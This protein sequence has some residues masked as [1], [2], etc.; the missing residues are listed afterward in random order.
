MRFIERFFG[1]IEWLLVSLFLL[2]LPFIYTTQLLDPVLYSRFLALTVFILL[3]TLAFSIRLFSNKVT[4]YFTKVDKI[5]FGSALAYLFINVISSFGVI[6]Y[7]EALFHLTKETSYILL[8]FYLYQLLRNNSKGKDVLIKSVLIMAAFYLAIGFVQLWR[9]DFTQFNAATDNYGYYFR[10]AI[11]H[12]LST[13][14][15]V[16]LFASFLFISLPFSIYGVI[17]YRKFWRIFSA[18]VLVSALFFI[19]ILA[20]K[21]IWGATALA[22]FIGA[23]LLYFYLFVLMPKQ[24]GV[25]LSKSMKMILLLVPITI[26]VSGYFIV[27]KS[28]IKLV[29][30]VSDKISQV[31]D[32]ETTLQQDYGAPMPTS[33]QTRVYVWENTIKLVKEHPVFGIGGGQW[34]IEY[35]K[36]GL[37]RFEHDIRNGTMLFQRPH[38]DFLWILSENGIM[39]FF[40]YMIIY[41]G[42]LVVA[43]YNFLKQNEW[44]VRIFSALAFAFLIGFMVDMFVSFPR[45]RV[46]HNSMLAILFALVLLLVPSD[47]KSQ[48]RIPSK[49]YKIA[50]IFFMLILTSLNVWAAKQYF[51]GE[52]AARAIKYGIKTKNFNL[53]YRAAR[54]VQNTLY[55]LDNFT[56]PMK[57]YEGVA[58]TSLKNLE[59]AKQTFLEAYKINPYHLQVINNLAT[60]YDLTGDKQTALKYYQLALDISPR[61]K[62]AL[63]NKSIV[64]YNLNEFDKAMEY[65]L[66]IPANEKN[67]DKF[68]ATMLTICKRKAI[69]LVEKCDEQKFK[70]WI[71]DPNKVK[72]TFVKVQKEKANFDVILL[73]ELAK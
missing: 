40:F 54:S 69:T 9:S 7:K 44:P 3:L 14:A 53:T 35:P 61:Y 52:K 65:I 72:A 15:N 17:V 22:I 66:Q 43:L 34:W 63:I 42:I 4:F 21:G 73:Q 20:S 16:L 67:P 68:E 27:Q 33:T 6:N 46:T 29:K 60:C 23:L 18:L 59:E 12:V 11:G 1:S 62:E 30:M 47:E 49:F 38:N 45:E 64:H 26:L 39:G 70:N 2:T 10:Q 50:L 58:L 19:F 71:S 51:S 56:T 31:V 25:S 24:R 57:Y 28:D 5:I 32:A 55:T 48:K 13:L 8:F 37:D 41:L 36:Y